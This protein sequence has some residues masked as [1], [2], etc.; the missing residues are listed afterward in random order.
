MDTFPDN[1]VLFSQQQENVSYTVCTHVPSPDFLFCFLV[2]AIAI[3]RQ[4]ATF[5]MQGRWTT[6]AVKGS[7]ESLLRVAFLYIYRGGPPQKPGLS[8]GGQAPCSTGFP[9]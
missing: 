3:F 9:C 2:L 1:E 7:H 4:I 6:I 5:Q 8:S